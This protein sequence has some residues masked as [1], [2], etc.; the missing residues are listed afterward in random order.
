MI[1]PEVQHL[2]RLEALT[3][4]KP[5]ALSPR[6]H[7]TAQEQVQREFSRE[8]WLSPLASANWPWE[9]STGFTGAAADGRERRL[10]RHMMAFFSSLSFWVRILPFAY[11]CCVPKILSAS[12]PLSHS[13]FSLSFLWSSSSLSPSAPLIW[14]VAKYNFK[15]FL[16]K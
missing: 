9:M 12:L 7:K 3:S 10:D 13:A 6:G 14:I 2:E 11:L 15:H 16:I 5:C 8:K 1:R 4:R